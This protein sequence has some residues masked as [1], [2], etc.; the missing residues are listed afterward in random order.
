MVNTPRSELKRNTLIFGK[1]IFVNRFSKLFFT[2]A[3]TGVEGVS[4]LAGAFVENFFA[5]KFAVWC[6]YAAFA[7]AVKCGV[8]L[9][10]IMFFS[11]DLQFFAAIWR[12]V[13]PEFAATLVL[14]AIMYVPIKK[15]CKWL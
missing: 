6:L 2:P 7:S 9:L 5:G 13:I 3:D 14:G 11:A 12:A 15:I 4:V 1:R 8:S 10:Y